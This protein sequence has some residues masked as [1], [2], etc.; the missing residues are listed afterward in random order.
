[1][2]LAPAPA[3]EAAR[4]L[5][6]ARFG[7]PDFRPA[8]VGAVEAVLGGHDALIVL[9]TGGGKS[10]CYQVPALVRGGLT[11]VLSP[12]ISLMKDQVETLVRR[13]LPAA[14]L[15]STLSGSEVA[16]RPVTV[17]DLFATFCR[18]MGIDPAFENMAPTGRPIK[19]VDGGKQVEELF[20]G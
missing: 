17:P 11:L 19:L 13:G 3:L 2:T 9:P 8:Q 5:L 18:S 6:R 15:N 12:L 16:D 1:M 20:T 4:A 14:Y 10:L 7:Y